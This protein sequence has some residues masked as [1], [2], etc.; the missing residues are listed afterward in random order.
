M[1][2]YTDG[3]GNSSP[4]QS[5]CRE[6]PTDGGAW[7]YRPRGR[8]EW[9]TT[10]RPHFLTCGLGSSPEAPVCRA[11]MEAEMQRAGS[12]LGRER[13]GGVDTQADTPVCKTDGSGKPPRSRGS[14][15]R[16]C[17]AESGGAGGS[18]AHEGAEARMLRADSRWCRAGPDPANCQA[19]ISK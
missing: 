9:D 14:S 6:S 16:R 5:S 11:G 7:S 1:L 15:A 19:T 13:W 4:L 8:K 2:I 3:Q 12:G 17:E 10:E 18:A